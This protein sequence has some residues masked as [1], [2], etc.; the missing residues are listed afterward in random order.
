MSKD[1]VDLSEHRAGAG[2]VGEREI[3]VSELESYLH[4]EPR[5][6][7]RKLRSQPLCTNEVAAHGR[8]FSA[9]K[10]HASRHRVDERT[11]G[12]VVEATLSYL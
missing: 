12:L 8:R 2:G 9:M 4:G 1:P 6:G 3:R 11:R 10:R 7:I 5:N